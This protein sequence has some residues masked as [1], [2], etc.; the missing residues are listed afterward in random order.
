MEI[1]IIEHGKNR[2]VFELKGEGHT[3]C[4][5]LR[6]ELWNDENTNISD[7]NISHSLV[8]NPYFVVEVSKGDPKRVILSAVERLRKKN[9]ELK[10]KFKS[11]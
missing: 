3:F 1:S 11:L 7:Y 5:A 6:K 8:S 4:N 2:L 10:E 9:K